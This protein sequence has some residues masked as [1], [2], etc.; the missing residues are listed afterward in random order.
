MKKLTLK[1]PAKVNIYLNVLGKRQDGYHK[2]ESIAQTISLCDILHFQRAESGINISCD[3]SSVPNGR[4]NL[5]HRAAKLFFNL[6]G[7]KKGVSITI[8]KNIPLGAGLGGGSTDAATTLVG[9]NMLFETDISVVRLMDLSSTLGTDVPFCI[10]TGTA[11]LTGKGEKVYPLPPIREGWLLLVYPNIHISTPWV[12]SRVSSGLTLGK[13]NGKLSIT[14]I[15]KKIKDEGLQGVKHLLY[16]KL[17][18]VVINN[19]SS[20]ASIKRKLKTQGINSILMSGSGST[21][22]AVVESKWKAQ[23]LAIYMQDDGKVYIAQPIS[24]EA[25]IKEE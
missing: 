22:F 17:E 5:V 4:D 9:L 10:K 18:E 3:S 21:V 16:N 13:Q 20:V 6:T 14:E 23:Q 25:I 1:A 11:L 24:R 8:E 12:Y 15:K 2:I 19:F 7:I